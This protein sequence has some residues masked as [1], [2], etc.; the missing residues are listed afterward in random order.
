MKVKAAVLTKIK[1]PLKIINDLTFPKLKRG[2]VLVKVLHSAI[3]RSQI[4]EIDG[5]RGKDKYIPHLLG[6][7]GSGIVEK[8]CKGVTKVQHGNK[9]F[10]SWIKGKGLESGGT[11]I[12]YNNLKNSEYNIK[13][14]LCSSKGSKKSYNLG[15]NRGVHGT[16]RLFRKIEFINL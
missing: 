9:V 6:H 4:M 1:R 7:E 8:V 2:Q 14:R 10:L 12:R 15:E 13:P 11:K 3:C 5:K 16:P